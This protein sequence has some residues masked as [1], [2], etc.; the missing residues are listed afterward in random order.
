MNIF[1][2]KK[3]YC[4]E[5]HS[6]WSVYRKEFIKAKDEA[7]AWQKIK[8]QNPGNADF[9]DNIYEIILKKPEMNYL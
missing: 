9:C 4:V 7:D 1:S 5:W 3:I 6:K 2:K 8:K